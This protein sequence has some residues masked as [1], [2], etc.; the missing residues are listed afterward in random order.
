MLQVMSVV[1]DLGDL[2]EG[3]FAELLGYFVAVGD[4]VAHSVDQV[5]FRIVFGRYGLQSQVVVVDDV[6]ETSSS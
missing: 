4:E 1:D 5:P 2:A 6:A 3:S